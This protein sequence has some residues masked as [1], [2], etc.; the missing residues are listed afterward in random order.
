M[1]LTRLELS[2]EGGWVPP[3]GTLR[4]WT[5]LLRSRSP[6][7]TLLLLSTPRRIF[8]TKAEVVRAEMPVTLDV[9]VSG[10]GSGRVIFLGGSGWLQDHF[11]E[12]LPEVLPAALVP[13]RLKAGS[14]HTLLSL[15]ARPPARF[16]ILALAASDVTEGPTGV[17]SP[18]ADALAHLPV[19]LS[20]IFAAGRSGS[21]PVS[22][23]SDPDAA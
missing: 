14:V 4:R 11:A 12:E 6:F 21:V 5:G 1:S 15:E 16:Q 3:K 19:S 23:R 8:W 20:T 2:L 9:H 17:W 22:R 13:S 18:G 7:A 10:G